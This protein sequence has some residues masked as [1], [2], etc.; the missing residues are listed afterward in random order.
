[1]PST[2][3]KQ[4]RFMAAA[5]HN[6]K[7][8]KKVGIKQSVAKEFNDAD[9][10]K[11]PG[12]FMGGALNGRLKDILQGR[13]SPGMPA[14]VTPTKVAQSRVQR[15]SGDMTRFGMGAQPMPLPNP[16]RTLGH[17]DQVL[18]SAQGSLG[19]MQSAFAEGGKVGLAKGAMEAVKSAVDH[20]RNGDHARALRVLMGSDASE[21]P[22][23]QEVMKGLQMASGI[24]KGATRTRAPKISGSRQTPRAR[25]PAMKPVTLDIASEFST[26]PSKEEIDDQLRDVLVEAGIGPDT[27][28]PFKVKNSRLVDSDLRDPDAED[29]FHEVQLEI[30]SDLADL[31]HEW[32]RGGN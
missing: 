7:F 27:P 13:G 26:T 8:A 11:K 14:L 3:K 18:R 31:I 19:N 5:A 22:E 4:A 6:P 32:S 25:R 21:H 20:L 9:R 10:G 12:F 1:M 28:S 15:P 23:V 29:Y 17:A 2:S 30:P 24:E 16:H